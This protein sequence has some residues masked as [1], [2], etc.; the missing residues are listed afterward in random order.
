MGRYL[1]YGCQLTISREKSSNTVAWFLSGP[2]CDINILPTGNFSQNTITELVCTA[3]VKKADD[4]LLGFA[5]KDI[6]GYSDL[7]NNNILSSTVCI[8][9]C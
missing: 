3:C 2:T 1:A 8:K 5:F 4:V 7:R 6:M 9:G